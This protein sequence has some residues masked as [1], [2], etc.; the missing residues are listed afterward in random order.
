M[1][2]T[3][4]RSRR[5]RDLGDAVAGAD[6]VVTSYALFRLEYDAYEALPWSGLIL[7]EAQFVKNLQS[8]GFRCA[9][10]LPAPFK[11]AVTGT[12]LENNLTELWALLSI[13]APGLFPDAG[14]FTEYYRTPIE[15]GEAPVRLAQLRRRVGPFLLRRTKE[16]VATDL[17]PKQEQV[18]EL[19]LSP[20]HQQVYQRH[21]QRERQK[22][23][24]LIQDE[25][26]LDDNRFLILRSLT[27][28]RQ[29]SLDPSLVDDD[30]R[31]HPLQQA[32]RGD[33]PDRR[34]SST[35][36]TG[37]WCSASSPASW[38]GRGTGWTRSASGTASSTAGPGTG[39]R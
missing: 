11:L 19:E 16:E 20:R 37:C 17:P 33:R 24:G 25:N 8:K 28:L 13:T 5:G 21:L 26:A 30:V 27:L 39:P 2:I 23:L 36:G 3:E 10:T 9:K 34:A 29:L 18:I 14:R 1:L 32:R 7:D 6:I 22:I 31:R 15:R 12:P 38:A 4:G 35:A